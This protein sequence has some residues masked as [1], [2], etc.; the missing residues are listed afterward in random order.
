MKCDKFLTRVPESW[1]TEGMTTTLNHQP[2]LPKKVCAIGT[3][4][5]LIT[6][7]KCF[8]STIRNTNEVSGIETVCNQEDT[9]VCIYRCRLRKGILRKSNPY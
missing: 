2:D 6:P 5:I 7:S 3:R 8:V 9:T 1:K 4:V